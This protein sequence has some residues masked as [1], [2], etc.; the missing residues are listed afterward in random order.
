MKP[1]VRR[2]LLRMLHQS[3]CRTSVT[4]QGQLLESTRVVVIRFDEIGDLILTLPFLRELRRAMPKARIALVVRPA[5]VNL[6]EL[7]P[8]IDAVIPFAPK[9]GFRPGRLWKLLAL[10]RA[11]ADALGGVPD[12]G[13]LPRFDADFSRGL[14]A[15]L[16]TGATRR[17]AYSQSA[18]P[19][20]AIADADTDHFLTH[21]I[22]PDPTPMHELKRNL[23]L[24]EA[25]GA[26]IESDRVEL[27]VAPEDRNKAGQ[28]LSQFS[29]IQMWIG[30]CAGASIPRKRWPID[31]Y[32]PVAKCITDRYPKSGVVVIGG[33]ADRN[34]GI[35]I[36][37][38]IA[39]RVLNVAG[40][41]TL[42][43]TAAVLEKCV[44]YI[45]NDTGPMHLAAAV[46]VPVVAVFADPNPV[47]ISEHGDDRRA[48]FDPW[49]VPYR[50]V[51]P[52]AGATTGDSAGTCAANPIASVT[53][54]QV[55]DAVTQ[56]LS[57]ARRSSEIAQKLPTTR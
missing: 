2:I 7:C 5:L 11:V 34:A 40:A 35:E 47:S 19:E 18:T 39:G 26:T 53:V 23:Y 32:A 44:L 15:L 14:M 31:R 49:G 48:R 54:D 41:L 17:I 6:V 50:I 20:K 24:L 22:H 13:I 8:Y 33:P 46:G 16:A 10:R 52:S 28:L 12:I 27:P 42:R 56:L 51:T 30:L 37:R 55:I 29:D 3:C 43:E 38:T 57:C 9:Y 21:P 45:G 4:P 25:M 36:Q 1:L